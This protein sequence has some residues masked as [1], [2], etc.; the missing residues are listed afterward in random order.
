MDVD[1]II[2]RAGITRSGGDV[3]FRAVLRLPVIPK[4]P[5]AGSNSRKPIGAG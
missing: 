3:E 4:A 1:Q 2:R 5:G